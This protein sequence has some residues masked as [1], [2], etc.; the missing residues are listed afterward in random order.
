MSYPEAIE[1]L[2]KKYGIPLE[3]ERN[4][5]DEERQQ[6]SLRES[7]LIVNEFALKFFMDQLRNTE[8]GKL[9]GMTYLKERGFKDA[10]I[11][12]FQLGYSPDAWDTFTKAALEKG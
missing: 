4:E 12:K 5:S 10:T 2:A 8:E 9:M 11:D 3:Y 1:Y 6:R 7:L